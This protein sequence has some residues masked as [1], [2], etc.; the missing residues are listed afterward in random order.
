MDLAGFTGWFYFWAQVV[1]VS[2]VA[3]IVAFAIGSLAVATGAAKD[4]FE[5]LGTPGP[6]GLS[7][8]FVF[9]AILTLILTTMVNAFGIRLLALLNNIGVATEILGMLVFG[10]ILL[11]FANVQPPSVLFDTFGAETA[12][13]G[14][15]PATFL[16]G[17]FM[18]V[19]IVY[20]FDT[21]GIVRRR[22]R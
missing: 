3:A 22:D 21:A 15:M 4:A 18:S 7:T 19:F 12:Q 5:Y 13:N 6:A 10:I 16:L 20:G 17:F 14:N 11:V 9:I 2:A 1:T 8:M